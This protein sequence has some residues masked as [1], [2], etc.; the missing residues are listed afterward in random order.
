[1]GRTVQLQKRGNRWVGLCPFHAEKTPSFGVSPDKQLFHCFGCGAGGDLIDYV[2]RLEGLEFPDAVRLLAD[3]C[4]VQLPERTGDGGTSQRQDAHRDALYTAHD[5]AQVSFHEALHASSEARRYLLEERGLLPETVERFELGWAPPEWTF[6]SR[7]FDASSLEHA[8]ELGLVGRRVRDAKPYDRFRGRIMFP[9]RRPDG[10]IAAFGAR[11]A[12]WVE[13]DGP[14]YLNSP[15][16]PIYQKSEVLYGLQLARD[17]IRKRRQALLVEGYLDVILLAQAGL[18]QTVAACGTALTEE[19]ARL[20][21]RLAQEVVTLYDGD[22]AG[23]KASHRAA[24]LL[25]AAGV[26]VRVVSM[27]EGLDPDDLIRREGSEALQKRID[28]APSAIDFFLRRARAAATGGGVAGTA[29]AVEAIRPLLLAMSD[30]LA[31]DV[32]TDACARELDIERW[33]LRRHLRASERGRRHPPQRDLSHLEGVE[34]Q[35]NGRRSAPRPHVVETELLKMLLEDPVHIL[36]LLESKGALDAFSSE[37]IRAAVLAIRDGVHE[38]RR[39]SGPEALAIVR[40]EGRVDE[41]WLGEVRARL[42]MD[43]EPEAHE[44]EALVERLMGVYRKRRVQILREQLAQSKDV[45]E[46]T[47]ILDEVRRVQSG[48]R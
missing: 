1:M 26:E 32:A 38:N 14:K 42:V 20:L 8:I 44:V 15:E 2:V 48:E 3:A 36:P 4:G 12:D 39:L 22:L 9:I 19:H 21:G 6:L 27:P 11:R 40:S 46:Q 30:P 35:S 7:Q 17:D 10:R 34:T 18:T 41:A 47:R 33:T 24:R 5:R 29:K 23:R 31:R 37:P 25:L 28:Q 43:S 45:D 13:P 16:S